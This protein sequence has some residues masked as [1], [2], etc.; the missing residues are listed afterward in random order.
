MA[1]VEQV[2]SP[3]IASQ[4]AF[5]AQ[6]AGAEGQ[7]RT[8]MRLPLRFLSLAPCVPIGSYSLVCFN[9]SCLYCTNTFIMAQGHIGP[10]VH[11]IVYETGRHFLR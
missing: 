8:D 11:A 5:H 1:E 6:I 7:M 4:R 3:L 10:F 9:G 2:K